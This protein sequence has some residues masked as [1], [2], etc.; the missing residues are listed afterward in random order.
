VVAGAPV[1]LSGRA[2]SRNSLAGVQIREDGGEALRAQIPSSAFK[3]KRRNKIFRFRDR[4][5]TIASARGIDKVML[6]L[7]QKGRAVLRI[8]GKQVSLAAPQAGPIRVTLGF[9]DQSTREAANRCTGTVGR[10]RSGRHG[11]LRFP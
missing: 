6:F 3:A 1:R 5:R 4:K 2:G 11:Q 9:R 10:F 8:D 7:R